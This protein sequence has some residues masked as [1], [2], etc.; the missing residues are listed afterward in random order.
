MKKNI[1][2]LTDLFINQIPKINKRLIEKHVENKSKSPKCLADFRNSTKK[3]IQAKDSDL[4]KE[5]D[6]D[7]AKVIVYDKHLEIGVLKN[8]NCHLIIE[9]SE[10]V[11]SK[12]E[13]EEVLWDFHKHN[14]EL[15]QDQILDDLHDRAKEFLDSL[16]LS[17]SLDEVNPLLLTPRQNAK[18]IYLIKEFENA[19]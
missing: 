15:S 17:C 14:I 1:D 7:I 19:V 13:L 8:G 12:E 11:D 5:D 3:I 10:F 18:R 9:R 6:Y 16:N 2:R 4:Y